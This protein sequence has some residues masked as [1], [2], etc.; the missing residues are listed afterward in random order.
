[1]SSICLLQSDRQYCKINTSLTV[2]VQL[3]L[4]ILVYIVM[5]AQPCLVIRTYILTGIL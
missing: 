1:M 2:T 3:V 5:S 4:G